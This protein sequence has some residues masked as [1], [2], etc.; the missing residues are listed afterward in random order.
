M[1][2]GHADFVCLAARA[3][4]PRLGVRRTCGEGERNQDHWLARTRCSV[5]RVCCVLGVLGV[6]AMRVAL[7]VGA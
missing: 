3:A 1:S 2:G 7:G 4:G 6:L 5:Y